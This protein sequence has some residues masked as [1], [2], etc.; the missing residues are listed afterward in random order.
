MLQD[1][2]VIVGMARTPMGSFQGSLKDATG[3]ELGATAIAGAMAKA[4]VKAEDIQE[5]IMGC[6]LPHGQKQGPARIAAHLAGLPRDVGATTINKLCGSP[7]AAR[8]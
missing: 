3:P 5:V 2:I 7:V 1:P 6:V 8:T 4:G